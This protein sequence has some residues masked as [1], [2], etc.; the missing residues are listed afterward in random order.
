MINHRLN[1][2]DMGIFDG[3]RRRKKLALEAQFRENLS[4]RGRITDGQ[5][6]EN[7]T[8]ESGDVVAYYVYSVQGADFE[9]SEI[10]S[11]EQL[12]NSIKYAPGASVGVRYDPRHHGSS[13]LV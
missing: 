11:E 7:E 1:S 9:S 3:I 12:K 4:K 13:I 5:I 10:L 2:I 8:L 6:I